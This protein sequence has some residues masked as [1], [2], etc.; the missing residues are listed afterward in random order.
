MSDHFIVPQIPVSRVNTVRLGT[1]NTSGNNFKDVDAGKIVKLAGESRYVLAA[2]GDPIE[3]VVT[4]VEA[5]TQNGYSIGGVKKD[6]MFFATA[7]GLQATAGTGTLAVGDY[8]V[9]GTVVALNTAQPGYPKVCKA[10]VQPGAVPADLTAASAQVKAS[11]FAWRVVSLTTGAGA[12][13][14]IVVVEKV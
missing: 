7:D 14:T 3:G 10:T 13:G 8:V 11:L 1:D 9:T 4:A 12:V 2:Q 5:A 6:E